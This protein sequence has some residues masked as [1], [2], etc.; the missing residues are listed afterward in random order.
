MH[1]FPRILF[2][3]QAF[4]ADPDLLLGRDVHQH[5]AF[6]DDRK[7]ELR[8]LVALRQVRIEVVLAVETRP[9]VDLRAQAEPGLHRLLDAV[10]VDHRQHAGEARVHEA[11]LGVRRGAEAH[12]RAREQLGVAGHLGVDLQAHHHF[13]LARAPR[14]AEGGAGGRRR[15]IAHGRALHDFGRRAREACNSLQPSVIGDILSP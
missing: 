8:D 9:A 1:R 15:R 14:Y 2:E 13:P 5:L 10:A 7:L 4:D 12:G 6:A 3:M 11:D